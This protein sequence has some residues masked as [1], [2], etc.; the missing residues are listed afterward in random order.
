MTENNKLEQLLH[1]GMYGTPELKPQEKALFLSNFAERVLIALTRS[2]V[3]KNGVYDEIARALKNENN[4][5]LY[6]NGEMNYTY[7]HDYILLANKHHIPF[8]V[9][10][11]SKDSPL[12]L[13]IAAGE[14]V[15]QQGP[16]FIKDDLYHDDLSGQ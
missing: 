13:V 9:I 2:Q 12:G 6:V 11:D 3:R 7:Y 8:T 14:A 1:Q 15:H 10:N 16:A 4:I 5:R